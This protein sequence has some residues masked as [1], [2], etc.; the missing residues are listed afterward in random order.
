MGR[1]PAPETLGKKNLLVL[2]PHPDDL[3]LS[4]GLL[5]HHAVSL[6]WHVHE[7]ILTDG[8]GGGTDATAFHT[9]AHVL[10]RKR[11][12]EAAAL[13]LGVSSIK[14]CEFNDGRLNEQPEAVHQMLLR[15]FDGLRPEIVV[16][17]SAKDRHKDHRQTHLSAKRALRA[18]KA[19]A[20]QLQYCFWGI[21]GRRAVTLTHVAGVAAK[22]RAIRHHE[23]QPIDRYM[24]KLYGPEGIVKAEEFFYCP[25][26]TKTLKALASWGFNV[27]RSF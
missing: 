4:V 15:T 8:A 12:A 21:D 11:E 24:E 18:S 5:C 2:S 25:T 9:A 1:I 13:T 23:S 16:F 17:P 7:I 6:G 10:R 26:E 27:T 19:R 14:F 3:E 22:E 20:H